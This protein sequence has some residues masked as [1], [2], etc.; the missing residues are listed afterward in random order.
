MPRATPSPESFLVT[1]PQEVDA[2]SQL[3][4][5]ASIDSAVSTRLTGGFAVVAH[6]AARFTKA[7]DLLI[8]DSPENVARPQD[9][10]DAFRCKLTSD[11]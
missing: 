3:G 10:L 8:D 2:V 9:A 1:A 4:L 11:T 5:A 6:G 7:V